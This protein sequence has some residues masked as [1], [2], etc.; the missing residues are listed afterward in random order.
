MNKYKDMIAFSDIGSLCE[1]I[2]DM[3]E[4][5][6]VNMIAHRGIVLETLRCIEHSCNIEIGCLD[7]DFVNDYDKEYTLCTYYDED[8]DLL[9]I[10]IEKLFDEEKNCYLGVDGYVLIHENANS[11]ALRDILDN[12]NSEVSDYDWFAIGED[13]AEEPVGYNNIV[14]NKNT[15]KINDKILDKTK[16][17]KTGVKHLKNDEEDIHGFILSSSDGDICNIY[18]YYMA[19]I[20][21]SFDRN[22]LKRFLRELNERLYDVKLY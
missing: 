17:D 19:D 10:S 15:D 6:V 1:H 2:I 18:S 14:E 20:F 4:K 9:N 12:H 8:S 22:G 11:R 16:T 7:I 21:D 13:D 5:E 3:A